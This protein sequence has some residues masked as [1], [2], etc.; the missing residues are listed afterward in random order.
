MIQAYYFA[1]DALAALCST[2]EMDGGTPEDGIHHLAN[3]MKWFYG[4]NNLVPTWYKDDFIV[5]HIDGISYKLKEIYDISFINKYGK[6]FKVF[7]DQDSG[8]ICFGVQN[9]NGRYFV[10]F[11]GAP[12][13]RG[14]CPPLEAVK[15]LKDS[16][17][18]YCDLVHPVL[19]KLLDEEEL[20]GGYALIF[21]WTDGK[22]MGHMYQQSR[23][24]FMEMPIETK[25]KVFEDI[26]EFHIHVRQCGYVAI[27]FYDGSIM[28]DSKKDQTVI[29]DIDFYAKRP[30]TNNMGHLWGSSRFMFPEE[31]VLGAEIDEVTNVYTMGATAFALFADY[32]KKLKKWSLSD[33]R[34]DAAKK[35]VSDS[36][37]KRQQTIE[38]FL[39]EW[40]E[41]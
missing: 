8:N 18:A 39:D 41:D 26:V 10:K 13:Q 12:T 32:D 2:Y 36:R 20:N 23:Q 4:M 1:Y 19:V 37:E 34:Y 3:V 22:C 40:G 27:D 17:T 11:A 5:Q 38:Q 9:E 29:C 28:Y 21:D 31:F 14:N 16:A 15:R 6:V 30:Y 7:D 33:K 24:P 35:A 25:L